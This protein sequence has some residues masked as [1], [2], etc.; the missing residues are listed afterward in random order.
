MAP[1]SASDVR[2]GMD[3]PATAAV[4]WPRAAVEAA[5]G[6]A[7]VDSGEF[8]EVEVGEAAAR[9]CGFWAK[10]WRVARMLYAAGS[11]AQSG[12]MPVC[13]RK[14]SIVKIKL[15]TKAE[16]TH[17]EHAAPL[18]GLRVVLASRVGL[19]HHLCEGGV[20]ASRC[21]SEEVAGSNECKTDSLGGH[22]DH[23]RVERGIGCAGL[24][25]VDDAEH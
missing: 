19:V 6:E 11:R 20:P 3:A 21:M 8:S 22:I 15:Q 16:G 9:T 1:R 13:G 17:V 10:N 14:I 24:G 7:P 5:A 4:L 23:V 18:G 2:R 12:S 25:G